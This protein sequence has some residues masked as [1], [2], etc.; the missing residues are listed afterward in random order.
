MSNVGPEGRSFK[1]LERSHLQQLA[2]IAAV[3]RRVFF[4]RRPDWGRYYAGRV[5]ATALCQG[6]ALHYLHPRGRIGI[7]DFDV[8]TFYSAHPKKRWYAKRLQSADFEDSTFGRSADRP[9]FVGRRVD[10]M[11]R[12]ID[13]RPGEDPADA[14]RRWLTGSNTGSPAL[15]RKKA[16]ILLEPK[17]RLGEVVWPNV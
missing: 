17:R 6:A 8:Y 4:S 13:V 10:L 5:I 3:D 1:K 12:G 16:V 7:N 9:E 2:R 14:I 11:G 15:L